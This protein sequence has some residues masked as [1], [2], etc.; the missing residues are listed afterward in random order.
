MATQDHQPKRKTAA[1]I[2]ATND[3]KTDEVYIEDWDTVV[4][5]QGLTKRQQLDIRE[6]SVVDGEM[7]AEKSQ[8][9]MWREGVLEPKFTEAETAQVFEK[10]AGPV[11]RVLSR[12]LEL[13]GMKPEDL[14]RKEGEF[15]PR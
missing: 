12:I 9:G 8:A 7:N 15:R 11:D 1:E 6:A 3:T 13:S 14:K 5:V 4:K 2:L 10:S